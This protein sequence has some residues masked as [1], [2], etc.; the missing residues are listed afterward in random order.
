MDLKAALS[1][2]SFYICGATSCLSGEMGGIIRQ[3]LHCVLQDTGQNKRV[4]N[5]LEVDIF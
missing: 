2:F 5:N 1:Q 3:H 4:K